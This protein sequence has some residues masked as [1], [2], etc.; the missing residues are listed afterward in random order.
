M[1]E[2]EREKT[3]MKFQRLNKQKKSNKLKKN[4]F[5]EKKTHRMKQSILQPVE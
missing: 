3:Q 5:F 2:R 4:F 1:I